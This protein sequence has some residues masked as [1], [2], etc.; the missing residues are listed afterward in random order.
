MVV[1]GSSF[2]SFLFYKFFLLVLLL[3]VLY[4]KMVPKMAH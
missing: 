2:I 3:L 1:L 4:S